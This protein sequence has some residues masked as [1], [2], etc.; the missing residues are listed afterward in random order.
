MTKQVGEGPKHDMEAKDDGLELEEVEAEENGLGQ[1]RIQQEK[2]PTAVM[3]ARRGSRSKKVPRWL[4][5]YKVPSG[6]PEIE[7]RERNDGNKRWDAM[8]HRMANLEEVVRRAL[9]QPPRNNQGGANGQSSWGGNLKVEVPPFDGTNVEFWIFKIKELCDVHAI[10]REHRVQTASLQMTGPAYACKSAGSV[11]VTSSKAI[12]PTGVVTVPK[13]NVTSTYPKTTVVSNSHFKPQSSTQASSSSSV[14]PYKKLT[15]E[16]SGLNGKKGNVTIVMQNI[17]GYY[18]LIGKEEFEELMRLEV[19]QEDAEE[20]EGNAGKSTVEIMPEISYNALEG[21]FHPNTLRVTGTTNET[22]LQWLAELGDITINHKELTMGFLW[23]GDAKFAV[24]FE[25]PKQL[26]PKRE[27]DHKINLEPG[28]KPVSVRPYRY[29]HFQ[30][31]EIERLV[32]EMKQAEIIRDS[33]SICGRTRCIDYGYRSSVESG[34]ASRSLFHVGLLKAFVGTLPDDPA[35]LP[36]L[37][38][39]FSS[40]PLNIVDQ[41]VTEVEGNRFVQVLVEWEG[42]PREE[43]TWEDWVTLNEAFPNSDLEDK[44]IFDGQGIDMTKQVGEGPKHDM[45]AKDDGLE[46]EEAEAEE[47][48]LGQERIQQEK[49]PTTVMGARHGNRSKKVPGWLKD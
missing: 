47:N 3:I 1:E 28:A 48:G 10:P 5:D 43:A 39:V 11:S 25:E 20:G 21:Q 46:L 40:K 13:A 41:R 36:E 19:V 22:S 49:D 4:K 14:G 29:P 16:E 15:A 26:P 17:N 44:V 38:Q 27:V 8:D 2:D 32:E 31:A 24:V 9:Q 7:N 23:N 34:R 6:T 30:K 12:I 37:P 45:E 33:Q 35:T 42:V 18:L